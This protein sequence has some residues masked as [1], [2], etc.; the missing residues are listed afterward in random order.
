M[1]KIL[2]IVLSLLIFAVSVKEIAVF[3]VFKINQSEIAKTLCINRNTPELKCHGKCQLKKV[4]KESKQQEEELPHALVESKQLTLFMNSLP[5][6]NPFIKKRKT[7]LLPLYK[8]IYT[9]LLI[10]DVFHPPQ[11]FT[12]LF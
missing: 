2:A 9:H 6:N 10:L 1:K 12:F 5:R 8:N 7:N 11:F 3:L 4:L